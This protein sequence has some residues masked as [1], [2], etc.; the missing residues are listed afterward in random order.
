MAANYSSPCSEELLCP[1]ANSSLNVV[2][3]PPPR[4]SWLLHFFS[5][6]LN[7]FR[8]LFF[9]K[10]THFCGFFCGFLVHDCAFCTHFPKNPNFFWIFGC[11][12]LIFCA[13]FPHIRAFL[14]MNYIFLEAGFPP[15]HPP[16]CSLLRPR[17][18]PAWGP[19][20]PYRR[21]RPRPTRR[22]LPPRGPS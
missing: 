15:R 5:R 22:L 8:A 11:F 1:H 2:P 9:S 6:I 3:A 13:R 4:P 14:C 17:R 16:S 20:P 19:H 7:I 10:H 18:P 21:G 12:F